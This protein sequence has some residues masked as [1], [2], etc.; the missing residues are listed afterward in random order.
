MSPLENSRRSKGRL[1]FYDEI[2]KLH[3]SDQASQDIDVSQHTGEG[4]NC[5]WHL[6]TPSECCRDDDYLLYGYR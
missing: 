5:S 1:L 3:V 6:T 4:L 2:C